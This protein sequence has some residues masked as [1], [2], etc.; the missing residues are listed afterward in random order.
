MDLVLGLANRTGDLPL[1]ASCKKLNELAGRHRVRRDRRAGYGG[2][3]L[4]RV[5]RLVLNCAAY[6]RGFPVLLAGSCPSCLR[7]RFHR[8][9]YATPL[10]IDLTAL[11]DIRLRDRY[12]GAAHCG[13]DRK[14]KPR[15]SSCP[16]SGRTC[17]V[18]RGGR[19]RTCNPRFWRPVLCQLS[20]APRGCEGQC[21]R[22]R[23]K[24][25][26]W[27]RLRHGLRSERSSCCSRSPSLVSQRQ[28]RKPWTATRVSLSS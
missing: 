7:R 11:K 21:I 13:W 15:K 20:Y 5:H 23:S 26:P 4:H 28:L 22:A 27:L 6:P 14:A 10:W 16:R 25:G 3:V 24:V 1:A 2:R 19:T 17:E 9:G 18:S 12:G 8:S